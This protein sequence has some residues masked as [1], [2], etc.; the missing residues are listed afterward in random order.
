MVLLLLLLLLLLPLL[1]LLLLP[2]LLVLLLLLIVRLVMRFG[3]WAMDCCGGR[4]ACRQ[5]RHSQLQLMHVLLEDKQSENMIQPTLRSLSRAHKSYHR[6]LA[7]DDAT[8]NDDNGTGTDP[9][10][11]LLHTPALL[12][13]LRL[14]LCAC[15]DTKGL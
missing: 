7:H 14:H 5:T 8:T 1:L 2:R 3:Q 15:S 10:S 12:S 4:G 6:T 13:L 11:M 9:V